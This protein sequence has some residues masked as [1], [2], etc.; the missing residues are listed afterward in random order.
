MRA[1][2]SVKIFA[3]TVYSTPSTMSKPC[4]AF[5]R[6]RQISKTEVICFDDIDNLDAQTY[7]SRVAAEA[8]RLPEILQ[9]DEVVDSSIMVVAARGATSRDTIVTTGSAASALYLVSHRTALYPP[10]SLGHLP[11]F[12]KHWRTTALTNFAKLRS[13]LEASIK[14]TFRLPVPAMKDR[15]GWHVFCV[16]VD[17]ASGNSG[18]YFADDGDSSSTSSSSSEE[19]KDADDEEEDKST[20]AAATAAISASKALVEWKT[21]LP[22]DGYAPIVPLLLQMDQVMIRAVLHHLV[23]FLTEG[24]RLSEQHAAW[25]YALLARLEKPIHRDEAVMLYALL[26]RLTMIRKSCTSP[27]AEK[28]SGSKELAASNL[29]I[30]ILVV[31]FEQGDRS[32]LEVAAVQT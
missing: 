24:F 19:E 10:P 4:L 9:A 28:G 22:T 11:K 1:Q 27:A 29:L 20:A 7:L 23:F 8:S 32:A 17:A 6:K 21:S 15:G 13:F 25:I 12:P 2:Q 14:P 26:K 31:Y 30:V 5:E 16:G 18:G 3:Y